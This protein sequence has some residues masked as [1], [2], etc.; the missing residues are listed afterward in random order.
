MVVIGNFRSN[1]ELRRSPRVKITRKAW[2]VGKGGA[3]PVECAIDN[4][5]NTGA[6]LMLKDGSGVPDEFVL[7]LTSKG[8]VRRRCEV[9]WRLPSKIGVRFLK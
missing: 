6:A 5:S 4:V 3:A 8:E 7:L 1:A 2:I 9:V